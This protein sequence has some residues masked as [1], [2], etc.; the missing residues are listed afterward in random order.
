MSREIESFKMKLTLFGIQ[1]LGDSHGFYCGGNPHHLMYPTLWFP[2]RR[3][4]VRLIRCHECGSV[5]NYRI[6]TAEPL[7]IIIRAENIRVK[8][9]LGKEELHTD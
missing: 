6:D 7:T 2:N 1:I 3:K 9:I 5:G 4:R 8:D